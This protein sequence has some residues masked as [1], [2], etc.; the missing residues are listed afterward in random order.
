MY[1]SG[2]RAPAQVSTTTS[3][4]G[5][6]VGLAMTFYRMGDVVGRESRHSEF[7]AGGMMQRERGWLQETVGKY[8]C[9]F[10]NNGEGGTLFIGVNDK[11]TCCCLHDFYGSGKIISSS[12]LH[13]LKGTKF[14]AKGKKS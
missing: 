8:V 2:L 3:T 13:Q 6:A 7:K 11:G 1:V 12:L 14:V 4:P 5:T 9:G 10:L